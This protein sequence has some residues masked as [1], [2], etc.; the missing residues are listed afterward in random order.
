MW[1]RS[2]DLGCLSHSDC[3]LPWL[4]VRLAYA[5]H[6]QLSL[7]QLTS[8]IQSTWATKSSCRL[9]QCQHFLTAL[10]ASTLVPL[11]ARMDSSQPQWA[12]HPELPRR[13]WTQVTNGT[14]RYLILVERLHALRAPYMSRSRDWLWVSSNLIILVSFGVIAI[15]GF[16]RPIAYIAP[17]DGRC[18]IGLQRYV[19]VPLLS[20]DALVNILLT[21]IFV[22]LLGPL[23]NSNNSKRFSASRIATCFT[24]CCG[25][26]DKLKVNLHTGNQRTAKK[27]ERLLWR[28]FI[29]STLVMLPTVAN[30]IQIAIFQGEFA[31]LCLALCTIDGK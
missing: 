22:H 27:I 19:A 10:L 2:C 30:L 11:E 5:K 24:G 14:C 21:F 1:S 17:E 20:V 25:A 15:V 28:T 13:H 9:A 3:A 29:G 6:A 18:R 8:R 31:W 7:A 12:T 16:L 23:I 26:S 4:Y